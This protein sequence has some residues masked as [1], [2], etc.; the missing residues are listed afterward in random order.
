M[1]QN[2]TW[3]SRYLYKPPTDDFLILFCLNIGHIHS[4]YSPL[5]A[6]NFFLLAWYVYSSL[7]LA[8]I[9]CCISVSLSVELWKCDNMKICSKYLLCAD[10][11]MKTP[12]AVESKPP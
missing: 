1:D 12:K 2:G 10:T 8:V 11:I 3:N 5:N 6:S 4:F 7:P 9:S